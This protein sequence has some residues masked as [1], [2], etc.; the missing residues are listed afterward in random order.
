M[1]KIKKIILIPIFVFIC[2]LI[3]YEFAP[4]LSA[5][6]PDDEPWLPLY[7]KPGIGA[8]MPAKA[9]F[10]MVS[11]ENQVSTLSDLGYYPTKDRE[12]KFKESLVNDKYV[13][14]F[15]S[16][17]PFITILAKLGKIEN[18]IP[19]SDS[20][21][22]F[23]FLSN[24]ANYPDTLAQINRISQG[25]IDITDIQLTYKGFTRRE[26]ISF[27]IN[28]DLCKRSI[29]YKGRTWSYNPF[30]IDVISKYSAGDTFE[31]NLYWR[32]DLFGLHIVYRTEQ[33][34]IALKD[35]TGIDFL[36]PDDIG[37]TH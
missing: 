7:N 31:R 6:A 21:Y 1:T 10:G 14:N 15:Y 9:E 28:G 8:S 12:N 30:I 29:P 34:L 33:E 5:Q 35:K 11:I 18:N 4:N 27:K 20:V 16:I 37:L 17:Y 26:V 13:N 19:Y 24:D 23:D 2:F 36:N 25:E 3:W 32:R 22:S